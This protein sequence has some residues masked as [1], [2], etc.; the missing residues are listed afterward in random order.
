VDWT[1][2]R[3]YVEPAEGT[4]LATWTGF[5]APQTFALTDAV[6][7]VLLGADPAGVRLTRRAGVRLGEL[8]EEWVL[9]VDAERTVV[10]REDG[11][12]R[13]WTWAGSR[14]N[15]VLYADRA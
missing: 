14:A 5:A 4:G 13:W 11:T 1:R 15:A 12:T 10:L 9:R 6:R 3:A 7:R 2:R 8:R